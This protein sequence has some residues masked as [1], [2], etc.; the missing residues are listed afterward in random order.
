MLA[1]GAAVST[2]CWIVVVLEDNPVALCGCYVSGV[3]GSHA[4]Q[5]A[6]PFAIGRE[7]QR[8]MPD[9]KPD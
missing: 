2:G 5:F 9:A 3:G 1:A 8:G 7:E 4:F 6:W